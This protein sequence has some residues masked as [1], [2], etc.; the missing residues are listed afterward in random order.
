M[1]VS[2][3]PCPYIKMLVMLY[4]VHFFIPFS[5]HDS[6][7]LLSWDPTWSTASSS[8]ALNTSTWSCWNRSRRW[9]PHHRG[10]EHLPYEDRLREQWLFSLDKRRLWGYLTAASQYMKGAYRKAGEG[11]FWRTCSNKTRRNGFKLEDGRL[12]LDIRKKFFT[13]RVVRHWNRLSGGV[14]DA[15]SLEAF[16]ARLHGALS[17]LV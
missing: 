10:L 4:L 14:V 8:K 3:D 15:S 9:A 7:P 2:P 5:P 12:R 16:K 13:V 11:L 17:S 6:A 1:F